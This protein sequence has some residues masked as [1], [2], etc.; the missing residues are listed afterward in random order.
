M[1]HLVA[2]MK[3]ASCQLEGTKRGGLEPDSSEV[4]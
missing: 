1:I 4:S 2:K 3:V